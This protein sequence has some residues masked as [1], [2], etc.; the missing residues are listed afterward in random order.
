MTDLCVYQ[1]LMEKSHEFEGD[2]VRIYGRVWEEERERESCDYII[3]STNKRNKMRALL[4]KVSDR[5]PRIA[6]THLG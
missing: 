1:Q 5:A 2:Q 4:N 6:V 3:I